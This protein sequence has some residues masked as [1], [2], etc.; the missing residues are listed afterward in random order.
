MANEH[1]EIHDLFSSQSVS[2]GP[3]SDTE[4]M[5][6][7]VEYRLMMVYAQRRRPPKEQGPTEDNHENG[8]AITSQTTNKAEETT[9]T[10]TTVKKK[11][12]KKKKKKGWKRLSSFF[13][14]VSPQAEE[15]AVFHSAHF[16]E[17]D[18]NRMFSPAAAQPIVVSSVKV[19]SDSK[20]EEVVDK[21]T[22]IVVDVPFIQ[23]D[24]ETD[25]P[26]N[27]REVEVMLAL[28]LREAGDQ[29]DEETLKNAN[30]ASELFWNYSFFKTLM[31]A[32][33]RRMGL[34]SADP[35]APGPQASPKTQIAVSCEVTSRLSTVNT[36]PMTRMFDHGARYLQ[37][38][39]SDW[40]QRQGGY[41]EAFE[42][43]E[44]EVQ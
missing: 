20:L 31:D 39:F 1:V 36:L 6:S 40:V 30:I 33:L 11:K 25:A 16:S 43:D 10:T 12:K 9:T 34:R 24:I 22:E 28:L 8:N 18:E 13:K 26:E 19:N 44:D 2:P 37:D 42:E 38:Y 32:L 27:S 3:P 23:P 41:E 4:S 21:L 5:E 14:C 17:D 29:I 15:A 7:S 35:D